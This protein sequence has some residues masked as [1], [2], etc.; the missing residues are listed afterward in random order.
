MNATNQ[1]KM[2]VRRLSVVALAV[3]MLVGTPVGV[4]ADEEDAKVILKAMSDYMAAQESFHS[5]KEKKQ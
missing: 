5:F 1:M 2:C 3:M 4:R